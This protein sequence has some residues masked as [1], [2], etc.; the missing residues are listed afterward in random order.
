[1]EHFTY[2]VG[3]KTKKRML[4]KPMRGSSNFQVSRLLTAFAIGFSAYLTF[5]FV[6]TACLRNESFAYVVST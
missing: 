3:V 1:M 6:G 4:A 5:P 2:E